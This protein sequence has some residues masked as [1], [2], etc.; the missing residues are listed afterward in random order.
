[1]GT[2]YPCRLNKVFSL[3]LKKKKKKNNYDETP[4]EGQRAQWAKHQSNNQTE[5]AGLN[6]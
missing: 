6:K 2:I 3:K 1:M 4:E 5:H